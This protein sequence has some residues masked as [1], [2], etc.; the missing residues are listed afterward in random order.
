LGEAL[1]APINTLARRFSLDEKSGA[2]LFSNADNDLLYSED[3]S[4]STW[5][6]LGV[7]PP[8]DQV[9]PTPYTDTHFKITEDTSDGFHRVTQ[10]LSGISTDSRTFAVLLKAGDRSMCRVQIFGDA[11]DTAIAVLDLRQGSIVSSSY[12]YSYVEAL[13]DGWFAFY[14]TANPLSAGDV[15]LR[16]YIDN[17]ESASYMGDGTSGIYFA[18]A[19]SYKGTIPRPYTKTTSTVTT[20]SLTDV[21][22]E[23]ALPADEWTVLVRLSA[24]IDPNETIHKPAFSLSNS[25]GGTG[26]NYVYA[27]IFGQE[28]RLR[29]SSEFTLSSISIAPVGGEKTPLYIGV[30]YNNGFLTSSL[31][32]VTLGSQSTS[33]DSS[34]VIYLKIGALQTSNESARLEGSYKSLYYSTYAAT[35]AELEALTAGGQS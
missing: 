7:T 21:S 4:D 22:R 13:R 2:D 16:L 15:T 11:V 14:F 1:I 9:L 32:G 20:T 12:L 17:E 19:W 5:G 26:S 10:T 31:N 30:S 8:S 3:F 29:T 28:F 23:M 6:K 24:W 35:A 34:S 33:V 27:A 18:G 25:L